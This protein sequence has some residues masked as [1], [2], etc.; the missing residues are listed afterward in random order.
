MWGKRNPD[1]RSN[2]GSSFMSIYEEFRN[3]LDREPY[4]QEIH[5]FLQEH[6]KVLHALV[7]CNQ[8]IKLY[9]KPNIHKFELDFAISGFWGSTD[10]RD[11]TLVE[12]ER[13]T[14]NIFTKNGDPTAALTH[15]LRQIIDWRQWVEDNLSYARTIF[16][17][18][19]PIPSALIVIGR[20]ATL[21]KDDKARLAVLM[22]GLFKISI[23]TYDHLLEICKNTYG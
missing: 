6:P 13:T 4:E 15:A 1:P 19:T 5:A 12:I 2:D 22:A 21:S 9:S 11:W 16:P 23:R 8:D 20:R 18:I 3:L 17:D 10:R 14:H 7:L